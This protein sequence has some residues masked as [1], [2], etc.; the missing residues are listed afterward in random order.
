MK[1]AKN[2][3]WTFSILFI[4]SIF[5]SSTNSDPSFYP[6]KKKNLGIN[7]QEIWYGIGTSV[8][9]FEIKLTTRHKQLV[10]Q[11]LVSK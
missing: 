6:E 9:N 8:W 3:F 2:K 5:F 1:M 7:S 11:I 4:G 10:W